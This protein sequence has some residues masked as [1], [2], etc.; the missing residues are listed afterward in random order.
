MG[1]TDSTPLP[2]GSSSTQSSYRLPGKIG[3]AFPTGDVFRRVEVRVQPIDAAG[4]AFG[5]GATEI[6]GRTI[7]PFPGE[8]GAGRRVQ[9]SDTRLAGSRILT[10][11]VAPA[12]RRARS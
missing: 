1:R 9:R 11:S 10:L 8:H 7:D 4:R 12:T 3:H 2:A 6:L 5:A